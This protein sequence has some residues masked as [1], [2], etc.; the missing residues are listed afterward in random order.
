[1]DQLSQLRSDFQQLRQRVN[2]LAGVTGGVRQDTSTNF[3]PVPTTAPQTAPNDLRN[4]DHSHSV[5]TWFDSSVTADDKSKECAHWFSN[6]APVAAQVLSATDAR[7]SSTNK[8]LKEGSHSTYDANYA[9]WGR[10][11]GIAR[12]QS[13]TSLDT[14][15]PN[16]HA[17]QPGR[18]KYI[19]LIIALRNGTI[20]S[21]PGNHLY[22]GIWDS[23]T[24]QRDWVK[25]ATD[26]TLT[27]DVVG[28]PSGTTER[29]YKVFLYTDRGYTLISNE[30]TLVGAPDNASFSSS[31]FVELGWDFVPGIL[32]ADVYRYD[33]V[34]ATYRLLTRITSGTT[35]FGDNNSYRP[36]TISGYPSATD[37]KPKAYVATRD[38][39]LD[40]VAVDG[41][42]AAWDGAFLNIPVPSGYDQGNTTD[43]L[44]LRLG[45][46]IALDR[47]MTDAVVNNGSTNVA[48]A[49]AVFT[50]LD[51]GR[52]ATLTDGVNTHS[53]TLT[54]VNAGNATMSAAWPYAN[55]ANVTL[56]ITGGGD[57]GLLVD[58]VHSSYIPRAVY[59]PN[60]EDIDPNKLQPAARPN[61]SSQGGVGPGGG[62]S[63]EGDGG[64]RC[65]ALET[66]IAVLDGNRAKAKR[67]LDIE[68]GDHLF[69][70]NLPPNRVLKA[71]RDYAER[72]WLLQTENGCELLCSPSHRVICG[73]SDERGRAVHHL[74]E[75]DTVLTL[76]GGRVESSRVSD[77]RELDYGGGVG[78]FTL[79]PGHI[80]VAGKRRVPWYAPWRSGVAGVLSHNVKREE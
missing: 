28:S 27:G 41:V 38:G 36:E 63:G 67:F 60:S 25:A 78:T 37:T 13:T 54:Y 15:Y 24:T 7:T 64:L 61:G 55:A 74:R 52:S 42:D 47:R 29:R 65:V 80:Y 46:T 69:S 12:L 32:S 59:S 68:P 16:N 56:Y 39:E 1:M 20:V 66:P 79:S 75:G 30:V 58:L 71:L 23:T 4:G 50:S 72:L 35:S 6:P 45:L 18:T 44:W 26:F 5:N 51:T 21:P 40:S 17:V 48:S 76:V 57:H 73:S 22:A 77:V 9:D 34:A 49:T 14:P 70:C 62:G 19:D 31:V 53:I 3:S 10:T 8:T 2:D 11:Q 33:V 43:P